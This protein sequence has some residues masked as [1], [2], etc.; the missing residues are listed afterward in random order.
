[1]TKRFEGRLAVVT[2]ASRGIG[3]QLAK[4]LAAEGAHIIAV[5]RTVGGL[6]DLDD[7]I[8]AAGG[9]T[10]LVP[11][12][13][14]DFEALDRLGHS[15]Y[16]RWGKLDML[17]GNAGLL[18]GL[19]PIG[20]I[21]PKDWDQ[22]MAVN[23]TANW[24]LLRSLDPLLR[25]SEAGR[26]VFFSSGA[27]HKCLPYWGVYSVSKAAL[28]ALVRTYAAETA[29]TGNVRVN[30]VNPGPMRTAMRAKAMPGENPDTLPHPSEIVAPVLDLLAS[31]FDETGKLYNFPTRT[32]QD[33]AAA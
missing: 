3:Y 24:R 30:L 16:E 27:A 15:I 21:D 23:V 12:D 9:S 33:F 8:Q 18:G 5:A 4:G 6:E 14:A 28:E 10:T 22:V 26:A 13:L 17:V 2:G 7:E 20:H 29:T 25:Q 31:D 19:S 11:L 1:M 32:L